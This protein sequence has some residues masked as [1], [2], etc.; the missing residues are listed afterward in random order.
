MVNKSRI[1]DDNNRNLPLVSIILPALNCE[2]F[3]A[4]SI[5]S[6]LSQDYKKTEL[7]V[8]CGNSDDKTNE[9]A[10][11][12]KQAYITIQDK[13]GIAGAFN[14]GIDLANG[15]LIAFQSGDDIW[16]SNKLS[17]Q[18][19]YMMSNPDC[20]YTFTSFRYFL[21]NNSIIPGGFRK[22]LLNRDIAG[23]TLESFMCRK[24]LFDSIGIFNTDFS[25]ALDVEWFS[26]LKDYKV[27]YHLIPDVLL[28][29][30][31]HDSNFSIT[32]KT[33]N[34]QIIDALRISITN[35]KKSRIVN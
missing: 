21:N 10:K 34:Q 31:V 35:R 26:R 11:S 22:D 16:K 2:K 30:R 18:V 15:D 3:L 27:K 1:P 33:N 28:F 12:F 17:T 24:S 4:D 8:V 23:P 25:S 20:D 9:I 14:E 32:E 29:K 19:N 13:A 5:K 7:I 6:V